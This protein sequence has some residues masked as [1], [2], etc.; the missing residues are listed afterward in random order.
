MFTGLI[1]ELGSVLWIRATERG[2]Q[3]QI[4]APRIS[5][6]L[7]TGD[8]IAVNGCCLTVA[9]HRHEQITFDLLA[10]TVSR[11]NL[12]ALR[13][14][15]LVNLER[16]LAANARLGGHFVQ[17]HVDSTAPV[18]GFEETSGGFRLEVG[19]PNEFARYVVEKGSV[20]VN[21][22]SL[23]IAEVNAGSFVSW[24][25]PHTRRSTTLKN[26]QSSDVVNLE[27]DVLAKY[28]ERLL[29]RTS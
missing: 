28:V 5:A 27:F 24:I 29:V 19:L 1:E 20:A 10:E 22:I 13:R 4:A 17:G 8:S 11:T 2:T 16:A 21:G 14:D 25:I 6:G 26:A 7:R 18:L 23:T 3:L 9:S 15:S 12:G